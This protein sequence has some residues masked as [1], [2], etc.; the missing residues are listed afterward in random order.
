MK[1]THS[2]NVDDAID[3]LKKLDVNVEKFLPTFIARLSLRGE[4]TMKKLAPH[5]TG[6]LRRSVHAAPTIRPNSIAVNVDYAFIADVR[7]KR[8]GYIGKTVQF[9][10]KIIPSEVDRMINKV[11]LEI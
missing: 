1:P 2:V 4:G 11:L 10:D 6:T 8:P 5:R 9:I 3:D 7:S